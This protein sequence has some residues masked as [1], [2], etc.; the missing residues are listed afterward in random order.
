MERYGSTGE[1]Q[2]RGSAKGKGRETDSAGAGLGTAH[3]PYL[4]GKAASEVHGARAG[5]VGLQPQHHR[6][7]QLVVGGATTGLLLQDET[8]IRTSRVT[9]S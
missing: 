7:G 4:S 3:P 1:T 8:E 6:G 2:R 9:L 5:F